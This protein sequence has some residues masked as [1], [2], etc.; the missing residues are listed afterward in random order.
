MCDEYDDERMAVF[1]RKL[2]QADA[3]KQPSEEPSKDVE[4]LIRIEPAPVQPTKATP[5]TLTR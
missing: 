4:P 3:R 2:E 1:W 5:K